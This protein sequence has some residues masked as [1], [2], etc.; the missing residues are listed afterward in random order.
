MCTWTNTPTPQV[1]CWCGCLIKHPPCTHLLYVSLLSTE[2]SLQ[3]S[4]SALGGGNHLLA[5]VVV[6]GHS[7]FHWLGVGNEQWCVLV[8]KEPAKFA[9]YLD[10]PAHKRWIIFNHIRRNDMFP[11]MLGFGM[12]VSYVPQAWFSVLA[13]SE[14]CYV[15][16]WLAV[17]RKSAGQRQSRK[18]KI[19]GLSPGETRN[20]FTQWLGKLEAVHS[21]YPQHCMQ[22]HKFACTSAY[23][24]IIYCD[25]T[26]YTVVLSHIHPILFSGGFTPQTDTHKTIKIHSWSLLC[27]CT[28]ITETHLIRNIYFLPPADLWVLCW[29]HLLC[30]LMANSWNKYSHSAN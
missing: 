14:G 10:Y 22:F 1:Q 25:L 20:L 7:S 26:S 19:K 15:P 27:M 17:E 8:G 3:G 6:R 30:H 18:A 11:F 2:Q 29:G 28:S 21:K 5:Y 13:N 12:A 4:N 23:S 9:K 24:L 16:D